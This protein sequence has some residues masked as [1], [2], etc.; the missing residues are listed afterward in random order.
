MPHYRDYALG[1]AVPQFEDW[2]QGGVLN[3]FT[4]FINQNPAGA[5]WSSF[6]L[7]EYK[8]IEAVG[9]REIVK[10]QARVH[11]GATNPAW[12][13]WSEDKSSIRKE[14]AGILAT[15]LN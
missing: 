7:L 9:R 3:S 8:N 14:Q 13:K 15:A 12:K 10:D 4:A 1:Y 6:F 5:P 11:L 2:M